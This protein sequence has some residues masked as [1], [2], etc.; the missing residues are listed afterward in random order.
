MHSR[1]QMFWPADF[2]RSVRIEVTP[3]LVFLLIL[4]FAAT[5]LAAAV[6]AVNLIPEPPAPKPVIKYIAKVPVRCDAEGRREFARMCADK[7]QKP[8]TEVR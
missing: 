8:F 1:N 7:L 4:L 5:H 2:E 6:L 3:R